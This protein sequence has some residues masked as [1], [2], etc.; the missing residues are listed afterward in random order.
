M[1]LMS[2]WQRWRPQGMRNLRLPPMMAMP[3][4]QTTSTGLE[5]RDLVRRPPAMSNRRRPP[6][7][8]PSPA[9]LGSEELVPMVP[10]PRPPAIDRQ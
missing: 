6:A 1:L 3:V 8:S 9:Q 10:L 2:V 7:E 5:I 4:A